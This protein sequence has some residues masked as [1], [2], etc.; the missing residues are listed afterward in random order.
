MVHPY[1]T[2]LL[3]RW[4]PVPPIHM[5]STIIRDTHEATGHVGRNKLCEALLAAY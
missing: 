4:V 1:G 3:T 2:E 5:R